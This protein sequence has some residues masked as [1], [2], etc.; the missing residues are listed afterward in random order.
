MDFDLKRT[1]AYYD[2]AAETYDVCAYSPD[3]PHYP[4]N[5]YRFELVK[6]L[7]EGMPPGKVLDAGCGTGLALVHLARHGRGCAGC[8][9]SKG[10]LDQARKNL[11]EAGFSNVRLIHAPLDDLNMFDSAS[12][13]HVLCLGVFPYIPEAQEGPCYRELRRVI[14][15]GGWFVTAHENELFDA[16]TF[17]KYTLRFFE[18][19][20]APLLRQAD[21]RVDPGELEN[22]LAALMTNPDLP[23]NTDP[24]RSGRDIIFTKPENPLTYAEKLADYGFAGRE[25]LYYHF[26]AAPP[27]L[28]N[29]DPALIEL[30]KKLEITCAKAWQG[31]FMASTFI[32]VAQAVET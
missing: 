3:G 23:V 30:S 32:N 19:N 14:K 5:Y 13:D 18:R 24:K 31:M 22:R 25:T 20:I 2:Q 8:D 17:N 6:R 15:P 11:D 28:R 1:A 7:I 9:V 26:H 29:D 16:F 21:D 4:A 10:M 12:F 27:L